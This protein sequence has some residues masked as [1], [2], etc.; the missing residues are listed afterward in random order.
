MTKEKLDFLKKQVALQNQEIPIHREHDFEDEYVEI[1]KIPM[2]TSQEFNNV[3][4]ERPKE[5]A[6]GQV[7]HTAF[8]VT[9]IASVMREDGFE[10]KRVPAALSPYDPRLEFGREIHPLKS[11]L[12]KYFKGEILPFDTKKLE[13][14]EQ[15]LT[16]WLQNS[17]DKREFRKLEFE[18]IITGTRED[19]SNPMALNTS[20]GLPF[21]KQPRI[22]KG[23]RDFFEINENGEV[24]NVSEEIRLE[25]LEFKEK[26]MKGILPLTVSYD[27]PKDELRPIKKALGSIDE[28]TPPKTRSVTCM[29]MFYIMLWREL[30]LDMWA[31]FHRRAD[32]RF[33]L[34]PGINP[35]GP[36]WSNAY[37]YLN[38]FTNVVDFDVSNWDGFV[39]PELMFLVGRII[40]KICGYELNSPEEI[41]IRA[42]L[43]EVMFGY[44][45]HG[46]IIYQKYRGIISGFPGTAEVNSLLHLILSLYIFL[47]IA[48]P[49][50][51]NYFQ[52]WLD[53]VHQLIYGDDI[54]ISISDEIFDWYNGISISDKYKF[55]GYPIT[56]AVKDAPITKG[57]KLLECSF[58]KSSWSALRP[59]IWIRKM[60]IEVAYDLIYW[61]R[62]KEQP[63][64]QFY[65]NLLD[66]LRIVFGHGKV[67]YDKFLAQVN[68]WLVKSK[69]DPV[70]IYYEDLLHDHISIYY[71]D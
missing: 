47:D 23:K 20:P 15:T 18:E 65:L 44:I 51:M 40:S 36:E 64:D 63:V 14:I 30:T 41:A 26:M 59:T 25:Y 52:A 35:E 43:T 9:P 42:I 62:A 58:L 66:S 5:E 6:I 3:I 17:L 70:Y 12:D 39:R 60:D 50:N 34:C 21:V 68:N 61:V 53:H 8:K 67:V 29:N 33:P 7:G 22:K 16:P 38:K 56:S 57:R 69:L 4:C 54:I 10:S 2:L 11:S 49:Y 31:T 37:H 71:D 32:G 19:G 27:F 1:S 28:D 48:E 24:E 13:Y 55:I 46:R 45:Q